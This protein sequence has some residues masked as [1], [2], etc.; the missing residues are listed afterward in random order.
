MAR[1][2]SEAQPPYFLLDF[3]GF[4]SLPMDQK[5]FLVPIYTMLTP[6]FELVTLVVDYSS[7]NAGDILLLTHTQLNQTNSNTPSKTKI[8]SKF[9][10]PQEE[11]NIKIKKV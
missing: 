8:I 11:D 2:P 9:L 7:N 3:P 5:L 4:A 6:V 10:L 1:N